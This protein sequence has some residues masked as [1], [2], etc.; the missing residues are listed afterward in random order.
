M[1]YIYICHDIYIY[2]VLYIYICA[3]LYIYICC[4]TWLVGAHF[5]KQGLNPGYGSESSES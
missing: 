4:A 3:V 2:A 1:F 5:P